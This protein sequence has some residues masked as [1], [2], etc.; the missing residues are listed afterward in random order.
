MN[1]AAHTTETKK[2]EKRR[3][4]TGKYGEIIRKKT[5][6]RQNKKNAKENA[7]DDRQRDR[8]RRR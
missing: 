2:D 7:I 8:Q 4:R 6:K 5:E 1:G 3:K